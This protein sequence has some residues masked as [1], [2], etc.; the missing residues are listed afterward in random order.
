MVLEYQPDSHAAL[1]LL[2]LVELQS[3]DAAAAV[4]APQASDCV[5]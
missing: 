3:G 5:G 2:G 4:Q 1:H